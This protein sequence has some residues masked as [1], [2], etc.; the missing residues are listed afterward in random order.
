MKFFIITIFLS[1]A[2]FATAQNKMVDSL[3]KTSPIF[4]PNNSF[5]ASVQKSNSPI[6]WHRC[7]KIDSSIHPMF[8]LNGKKIGEKKFNKIDI[9][10]ITSIEVLSREQGI[11]KYGVG[12]ADGVIVIS[13][14]KKKN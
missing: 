13:A 2:F 5:D 12:A 11:E 1:S 6:I 9:K 7:C 4:F 10:K 8:I 3:L 14:K